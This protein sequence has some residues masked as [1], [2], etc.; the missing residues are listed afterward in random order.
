M[1]LPRHSRQDQSIFYTKYTE[2]PAADGSGAELTVSRPFC[3]DT[4]S[5]TE[6]ALDREEF[7]DLDVRPTDVA[8]GWM[9]EKS[10]ISGNRVRI[11]H[12][13]IDT[14]AYCFD[15]A[16]RFQ[17]REKLGI[18]EEKVLIHVGRFTEQKK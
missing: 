1:S 17:M 16:V 14:K 5:G 3:Y 11:V 12:N 18:N 2:V 15:E 6:Y 13:G 10:L 4:R 8:A 9:Y 7:A